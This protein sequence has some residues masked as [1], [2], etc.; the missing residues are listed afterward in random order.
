MSCDTYFYRLGDAFYGLPAER[1]SSAAGVGEQLRLR[2]QNRDRRRPRVRRTA[3]DPEW[4]QKTFKTEI[5][6]LWKP[7]DSIQL[8]I[9]QKDLL[10]TPLQMARFYALIA[11]GGKLVTPHLLLDVEQS[12]TGGAAPHP[13]APAPQQVGVTPAALEIVRQGLLEATHASFGTSTACSATS[14]SRLR[15]KRARPKGRRPGDGHR[16]ALQPVVVVRLRPVRQTVDRRLRL[17]RE[18]GTADELQRDRLKCS[19]SSSKE[20]A[21]LGRDLQRLMVDYSG[22]ATDRARTRARRA[23]YATELSFLRRLDWLLAAAVAAL[24]RLRPLGDQRHHAALTVEGQSA[25]TSSSRQAT[26]RRRRRSRVCDRARDR[27]VALARYWRP[28]RG[29]V[30]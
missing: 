26:V 7:G 18:R 1:R 6:K 17:D 19:R 27:P 12:V 2:P 5:D 28:L 25:S 20:G 13:A 8:A 4:R 3:P 10:V 15:A 9:G 22:T 11:N 29:T 23:A 24:G 30:A 14:R 21:A 16:A